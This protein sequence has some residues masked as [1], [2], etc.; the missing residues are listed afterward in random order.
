MKKRLVAAMS[1]A[2]LDYHPYPHNVRTLRLYIEM[3][4][5]RYIDG[6][7]LKSEEFRHWMLEHPGRLATTMPPSRLEITKFFLNIMDEGYEEVLFVGM[8]SALSRT[9]LRVREIVPLFEGKMRIEV[10]D[11]KTGS[12]AEGMM[13]LEADR[14]FRKGWSMKRTLARLQRLRRDCQVMFGVSDLSYLLYNGRLSR[15]SALIAN[16]L[17]LKPLMLLNRRGEAE[18]AER[19]MTNLRAM[20]A[21]SDYAGERAKCGQYALFT[22]YSGDTALHEMEEVLQERNN[23][24]RLPAYPISAAVAAHIGPH[25]F[26]VGLMPRLP[27]L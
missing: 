18:V 16:V 17:Q 27:M 15:M 7:T 19:V 2:C 4:N 20:R 9:V 23:W 21:L 6:Q 25:A 11:T 12:F 5:H 8:S 22:M 13:A 3:E 14:C 24:Y 26:G 1:T 10:F